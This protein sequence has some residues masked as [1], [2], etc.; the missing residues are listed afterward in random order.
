[1]FNMPS[2]A[3]MQ[4]TAAAR[5]RPSITP[6]THRYSDLR[7]TSAKKESS[8]T[9]LLFSCRG[10]I[11]KKS[12]DSNEVSTQICRPKASAAACAGPGSGLGE[13]RAW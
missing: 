12:A 4:Q 7:P 5:A 8:N 10:S 6:R 13:G 3:P 9:R 2:A 1:M 11:S